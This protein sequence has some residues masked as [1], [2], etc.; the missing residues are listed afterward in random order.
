L[1]LFFEIR[2]N[3]Y[4]STVPIY[5]QKHIETAMKHFNVCDNK[6]VVLID[7]DLNNVNKALKDGMHAIHVAKDNT[8]YLDQA[9]KILDEAQPQKAA[10]QL[11][12]YTV[13]QD[14]LQSTPTD[15]G[16]ELSGDT[17]DSD[18]IW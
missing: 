18:E 8:E 2:A 1:F 9:F 12:E 13:S 10:N 17:S 15:S 16:L 14:S 4:L 5:K 6:K 7:D 3:F 11:S